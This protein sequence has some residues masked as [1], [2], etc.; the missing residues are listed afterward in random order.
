MGI[1]MSRLFQSVTNMLSACSPLVPAGRNAGIMLGAAIGEMALL[2]RDKLTFI[3]PQ[4]L[5]MFDAWLEQLIAES[6]GKEGKG[7]LPVAG[8]PL[9][10]PQM[11]GVDRLFVH[12]RL[13]GTRDSRIDNA[14]A[15]LKAAGQ[16]I[17]AVA[18]E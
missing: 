17:V 8:E 2:G 11:Y 9:A 12:I 4:A 18:R 3:I 5:S 16:P 14:V 10:S 13:K 7:I 15:S 6:T 1:D